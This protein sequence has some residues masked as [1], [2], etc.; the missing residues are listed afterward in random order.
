VSDLLIVKEN[1][2]RLRRRKEFF[3]RVFIMEMKNQRR[4]QWK[5]L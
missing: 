2:M 1:L 5:R 3:Q 4:D